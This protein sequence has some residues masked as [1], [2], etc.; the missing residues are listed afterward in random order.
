MG[1]AALL[2]W[3][4]GLLTALHSPKRPSFLPR[5][6]EAVAEERHGDARHEVAFGSISHS[7]TIIGHRYAHPPPHPGGLQTVARGPGLASCF[8]TA[9]ELSP[10]PSKKKKKQEKNPHG[11]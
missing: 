3:W 10:T 8:D 11:F 4:V 2:G 9:H 6:V 1:R 5:W 7:L